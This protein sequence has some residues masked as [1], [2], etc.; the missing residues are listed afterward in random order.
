M[1]EVVRIPST[2][3]VNSCFT[4]RWRNQHSTAACA[5]TLEARR[6]RDCSYS[7][8]RFGGLIC[9]WAPLKKAYSLRTC[10]PIRLPP[11]GSR[12][13]ATDTCKPRH[14]N[15]GENSPSR[16][17]GPSGKKPL[18]SIRKANAAGHRTWASSHGGRQ[19]ADGKTREK[20]APSFS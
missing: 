14:S 5:R 9:G 10:F 11:A 12:H 18:A 13:A 6:C 8:F 19:G 16:A 3:S 15:A 7:T 1:C 20:L 17:H 4:V 2:R